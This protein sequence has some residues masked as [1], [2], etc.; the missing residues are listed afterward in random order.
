VDVDFA[1]TNPQ[2]Q[3]P[4]DFAEAYDTARGVDEGFDPAA[5]LQK[6]ALSAVLVDVTLPADAWS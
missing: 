3:A 5:F 6:H 2:V 4:G 1:L